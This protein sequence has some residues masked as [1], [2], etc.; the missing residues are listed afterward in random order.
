VHPSSELKALTDEMIDRFLQVDLV[1]IK[2]QAHASLTGMRALLRHYEQTGDAKL[3]SAV[4]QRYLL[5]RSNAM[6]ENYANYNWFGRPTATEPCAIIDS[7]ILA[8]Q[9][10]QHT[11]N[12]SYLQ[13]AHLIYFNGLGRGQRNNGGYGTDTCA[14]ASDAFISIKHYEAY[15]CC[16]MRGGEGNARSIQYAYFT[17]PNELL[18]PFFCD[19]KATLNVSGGTVTLRQ[20]TE[21][22]YRGLVTLQVVQSSAKHP[23]TLRLLAPWWT[24]AH[25]VR[26][27]GKKASGHLEGA[28]ISTRTKL[29]AG[30]TI[31]FHFELV[32][33]W[34]DTFNPH[35][36]RG[37]RSLY[38][39]PLMLCCKTESELVLRSN[40]KIQADGKG[41]YRTEPDGVKLERI[42]DLNERDIST[43]DPCRRQVLFRV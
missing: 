30:D 5:Y 1:A 28:F 25:E 43:A 41:S 8:L 34:R 6:T 38:A 35:S 23:I 17:R 18:V 40:S 24:K 3:L 20:E 32:N 29:H 13:D 12:S 33:G 36:I 31:A 22:P 2:A 19:S 9:L 15:W 42:N 11:G 26:V 7:F 16:T 37:Y 39:G 14:G 10:W 4:E 21:Y 27:N